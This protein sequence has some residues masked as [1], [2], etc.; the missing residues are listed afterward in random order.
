MEMGD[1]EWRLG[2]RYRDMRE[3]TGDLGELSWDIGA[4]EG[5]GADG[6]EDESAVMGSGFPRAPRPDKAEVREVVLDGAELNG[7]ESNEPSGLGDLL[8]ADPVVAQYPG[9]IDGGP[10]PFDHAVGVNVANL[11]MVG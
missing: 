6:S 5:G 11:E 9:N 4:R 1:C 7:A 8:E 2:D 10:L 3:V